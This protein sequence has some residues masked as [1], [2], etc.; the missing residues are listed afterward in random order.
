[1][2]WWREEGERVLAARATTLQ[3][4]QQKCASAGSARRTARRK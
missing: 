4:A 3:P 2:K 1:M